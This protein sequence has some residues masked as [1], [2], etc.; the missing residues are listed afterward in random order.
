M[1]GDRDT[2]D[3]HERFV[4][5]S[6]VVVVLAFFLSAFMESNRSIEHTE[7]AHSY[8]QNAQVPLD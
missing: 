2:L 8:G 4:I 7:A 5:A 3:R 6:V 1:N